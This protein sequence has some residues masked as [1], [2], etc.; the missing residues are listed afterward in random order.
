M[1]LQIAFEENAT[2][3]D[4]KILSDGIAAHDRE[5]AGERENRT[6]TF[7]LRDDDGV[8]V[9]G[10]HGNYG[11][12]GWLY[13]ST[14][15]VS[16]AVRHK[17]YGSRLLG[18]AEQLAAAD[19]C[20]DVYLDTFSYGALEF[21]KKL[22]YVLFGELE[23]FPDEHRRCFLRKRLTPGDNE[24]ERV[25]VLETER[26]ILRR[27][28]LDDA[29]FTLTLL[30]EPAFVRYIGDRQIKTRDEA[31]VYLDERLIESYRRHG[32][33]MY[34][35][36][37]KNGQNADQ[38]EVPIGICGLVKRE[39][40]DDV[41]VGFAFLKDH[42]AKGYAFESASAVIDYGRKAFGLDRIVAITTTDNDSSIR[43]LEKLGMQYE[44]MVRVS[45]DEAELRLYG[46]ELRP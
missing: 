30:N 18:H 9:G 31:R 2:A 11:V 34:L 43:L 42:W 38:P 22:G 4:I 7:F 41:E 25:M 26:L 40:L 23:R 35:T 1:G 37:L 36:A 8:I 16:E 14:L 17:S 21:Y 27:L 24:R 12:G 15:W 3:D 6:V 32:F 44:K 39:A 10:V 28:S 19:G 20:T 13:I 33:G 29:D 5:I 46:M 45:D